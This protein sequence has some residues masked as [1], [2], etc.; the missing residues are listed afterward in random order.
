[1]KNKIHLKDLNY[2]TILEYANKRNEKHL[3]TNN[4]HYYSQDN[5]EKAIKANIKKDLNYNCKTGIIRYGSE[6]M[7]CY[8]NINDVPVYENELEVLEWEFLNY[9]ANSAGRLQRGYS[10]I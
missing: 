5:I 7:E 6:W 10:A 2:N 3:F 4:E 9:I 8:S 1:M